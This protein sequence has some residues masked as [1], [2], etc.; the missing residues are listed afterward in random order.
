MA[1]EEVRSTNTVS[2]ALVGLVVVAEKIVELGGSM[3]LGVDKNSSMVE[4][5]CKQ[6]SRVEVGYRWVLMG[7]EGY[8]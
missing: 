6:E 4:E 7:L 1:E 5:G 2:Q 3:E 8:K